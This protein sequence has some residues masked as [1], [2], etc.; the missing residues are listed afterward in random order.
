MSTMLMDRL[1]DEVRQEVPWK[2]MFADDIAM[3]IENREPVERHLER[4]R[5][6]MKVSCII[7]EYLH[8]N[9]MNPTSIVR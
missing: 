3:C 5:Y 7:P 1:T 9:E 8:G 6:G 4:W 2:E